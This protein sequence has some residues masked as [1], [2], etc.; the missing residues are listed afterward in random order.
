MDYLKIDATDEILEDSFYKYD[1]N[2]TGKIDYEEF[3]EIFIEVCDIRRELEDRG[4]D[5]PTF[6]KKKTLQQML[7]QCLKEEEDRE[8]RALAEARRYKKWVLNIRDSKKLLEKA[9]FRAYQELRGALDAAGHLYVI[10]SGSYNQFSQPSFEIMKTKKFKFEYF[11]KVIEVWKNRVLPEQL[12]DRLKIQR[13]AKEQEEKR[14]AERNL[15]GIALLAKAFNK[16]KMAIDPYEEALQSP[17]RGLNI[18]VNTASLW[19]RRVYQAAVSENVIFALSDTGEV[20]TWGGNS[21]WWH[22]IQPDSIFQTKWRGDTTPRSQLLMGTV[23]KTLPPDVSI[24]QDLDKLPPEERKAE[25]IKI[26]AKYYNVWEPPPN[27][28][29]RALYLEKDILGKIEYDT[30]KFS[31]NCRGKQVGD[32]NKLELLETLYEDIMLEKRLLGERAHKAIKEIELQIAG[33]MKRKKIK[34]AD[35]F[36]KRIDEMWTPLREVQAENNANKISKQINAEHEKYLQSAQNYQEWRIRVANKR[37]QIETQFTP[38]GHSLDIRLI[39]ATP[40]GPEV[41]TPR[42]FEAAM[43]ISSGNA[44]ACLI[45]KTGQLY[46]WGVGISGRLG[47]DLTEKGDPQADTAKPAIIQAL[48]ERAVVRVSCGYSHTGAVV[49]GGDLYM[50]G[51]TSGG[52]CGLGDIV[53]RE[54]CYCSI[55]T[56]VLVGVEDKRIKKVSC[57]A[58]HSAA[59]TESGQLYVFGCGDGGR[60][61]LGVGRYKS[62]MVPT[63]VESLLHEKV[64]SV[65][66]GNSVTLVCTEISRSWVGEMEDKYRKLSG[67]RLYVAGSGNV[68][69]KQFDVFTCINVSDPEESITPDINPSSPNRSRESVD[70]VCIKQVSAGYTHVAMVSAEGEVYCWG[71]NKTGCCGQPMVSQ[72]VDRP[73]PI[74]VFY[75]KPMNLALNKRAYQSSTYNC[76]DAKYA[77][78]GKKDGMGVNKSTCTQQEAQP[79]I[80]IDLGMICVID[81]IVV[82][83]RTDVPSDKNQPRDLYTSRL[84]PCWAMVGRDPFLTETTVVGLKENLR[85]SVCK[86]KFTE[87]KRISTW[88][89]PAMTQGRYVRLQL[90]RYNTLSVAEIEIY[91]YL[92][93]SN[94]VGRCSMAV[95][96]RDVTVAVI[97][98]SQDPQDVELAYK[99]AAYSDSL[100]ADILRQYETYVLEYDKFGRGD[101]LT[102]DSCEICKGIDKCESCLIYET[103]RNEILQMPPVIGGRRRRLKSIT[104]Y[105]ISSNKPPLEPIIIPR[106][107]RP[108]KW[109]LKKEAW[110]GIKAK[111]KE[112]HPMEAAKITDKK[113]VRT[114]KFTLSHL[115][116]PKSKTYVT[117]EEA[118]AADPKEIMKTIQ[119]VDKLDKKPPLPPKGSK[120]SE[121][122]SL[123]SVPRIP[124]DSNSIQSSSISHSL[125]NDDQSSA[126]TKYESIA[127]SKEGT[128]ETNTLTPRESIGSGFKHGYGANQEVRM[129]VG[130]VIPT[131]HKIKPAFPK[132]IAQQIE[133]SNAI[134]EQ[135]KKEKES[136]LDAKAQRRQKKLAKR[137]EK[138]I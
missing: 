44:H 85:R 92:G 67:G 14:D 84:F 4:I 107:L 5:V 39:G 3:R 116:W 75:T 106:S 88:R 130:D 16:K 70:E 34:L 29:Q 136:N 50:W 74:K 21:F 31:L 108:S 76:R 57:G 58:A 98:P 81:K 103:F 129:E 24:E 87:D 131:G 40:R 120:S 132:S 55:P 69:G 15:S 93:F 35:K 13:K 138:K 104:E 111:V 112:P 19:G 73:T 62:C 91:G 97:R 123:V 109:D 36:L 117:P 20:F 54:E 66:C 53:T 77:V 134:L 33:L 133:E 114:M 23:N 83:N 64:S 126:T 99:R 9:E 11:E 45:H 38:R 27:P 18:A 48:A 78:N 43:Q 28:A 59:I 71:Y 110:F 86:S 51:S 96:G 61:G 128:L 17:F 32:M 10:G 8:R 135:Q 125:T 42:G 2:L 121:S 101:I 22:E 49:S 82:Y 37:E 6:I 102:G 12:V 30:L 124:L 68:F 63:L 115:L 80:E 105:L 26:V 72:F 7:R 94:G 56:R 1:Y 65:S 100:N 46:T 60:L 137:N 25:M 122:G 95:A 79:W 119:Y 127:L 47:L 90:E 89:C 52:K 113:P 118:L 41:S